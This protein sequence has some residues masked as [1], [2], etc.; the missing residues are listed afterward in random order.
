MQALFIL[1]GYCKKVPSFAECKK[2]LASSNLLKT[3]G[4]FNVADIPKANY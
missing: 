2:H 1:L 4:E 3:L